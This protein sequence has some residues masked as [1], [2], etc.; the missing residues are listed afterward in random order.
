MYRSP[1]STAATPTDDTARY[2]SDD[3]AV[4]RGRG[5]GRPR[6]WL[7]VG[8]A[9]ALGAPVAAFEP[10]AHWAADPELF[11]LLR[12]M[13]VIK[14]MLAVAAFS[15]IWW[16]LG[17]TLATTLAAT[18]VGGVWVLAVATGLIWNLTAIVA[19]S[20]L[21]HLATIVLLVAAW[22]DAVR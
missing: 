13:A 5:F 4:G 8:S 9:L 17:R 6:A 22:R 3:S 21:F 15:V 7:V 16:R 11:R 1:F 10:A 18:Y 14:A 19:A 20:G 12:G 2:L